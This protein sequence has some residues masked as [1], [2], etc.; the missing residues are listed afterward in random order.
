M[1]E[2]LIDT[3]IQLAQCSRCSQ[4]VFVADSGGMRVAADPAPA[5]RDA[6]ILALTEGRR[7]F[8]LSEQAGRPHKLLTRRLADPAPTFTPEGA[9][10]GVQGR[11]EAYK[12]L[13][14]HPCPVNARNAVRMET[15]EAPKAPAPATPGRPVAGNP[16]GTAPVAGAGML[17]HAG[18]VSPHPSDVSCH[19]CGKVIMENEEFWGF[20]HEGQWKY[21]AH[22]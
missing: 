21:A 13:V 17:P 3:V 2:A 18:P 12:V 20:Q 6:Y 8:R 7:L 14:E 16:Q 5:T 9:Q 4:Y 15:V 11:L 22:A 1:T 19:E 10:I